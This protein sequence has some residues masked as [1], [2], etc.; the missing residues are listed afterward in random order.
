MKKMKTI[1]DFDWAKMQNKA[2]DGSHWGQRA[3]MPARAMGCGNLYIIARHIIPNVI[4]PVIVIA[5]HRYGKHNSL[6]HRI[7][8]FRIASTT[9]LLNGYDAQ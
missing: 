4:S 1:E 6:D 3:G 7:K 2:V 5:N 9:P 8:F